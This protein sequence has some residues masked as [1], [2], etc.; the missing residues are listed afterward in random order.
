MTEQ[1][2]KGSCLCGKASYE[3]S[4]PIVFFNYCH[5]SRCRKASGS[6]HGSNILIK[7]QQFNWTC[8]KEQV[9]RWEMPDAKSYCSAFCTTCGS[10]MPWL[11]RDGGFYLVPLGTLDD[12]LAVRP[13]RNIYWGSRA[14]WYIESSE[15]P[16]FEEGTT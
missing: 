8:D 14:D 10:K 15:V 7:K 11:T 13:E 6:A 2:Y 9:R 3:I 4:V 5:C 16:R 1:L 12:E